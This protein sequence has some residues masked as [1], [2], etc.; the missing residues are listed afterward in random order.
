MSCKQKRNKPKDPPKI[1]DSAP[2]FLPTV[3]GLDPVFDVKE[4]DDN[5]EK[6]KKLQKRTTKMMDLSSF[7]ELLLECASKGDYEP[8]L[9]L[10]KEMGPSKIDAEL[11][12]LDIPLTLDDDGDSVTDED[13][14]LLLLYFLNAMEQGLKSRKDYELLISFLSLFLRTHME[15]LLKEPLLKDA[16]IRVDRVVQDSWSSIES[17]FSQNLC[18]INFLRSFVA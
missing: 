10:L 9:S 16:C 17:S 7:S 3:A 1:P 2:F 11:R 15:I 18:I 13:K 5:T 14:P 12:C 8:I 6:D 4:G